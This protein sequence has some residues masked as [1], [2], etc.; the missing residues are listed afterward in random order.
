M[1]LPAAWA[2]LLWLMPFQQADALHT[3]EVAARFD[4]CAATPAPEILAWADRVLGE[5]TVASEQD[6]ASALLIR[7]GVNIAAATDP[8][9]CR[10]AFDQGD[11]AFA[12]SLEANMRNVRR[13]ATYRA[14]ADP[15]IAATQA[16]IADLWMTD[17]GGRLT[18]SQLQ[19]SDRSGAAFW[20]QRRATAHVVAADGRS[21]AAIRDLLNAYDWIDSGRFGS[22]TASQAWILVQH[23][24]DHPDFQ[25][26]ALERMEPY[27]ASGGV[28]SRDYAYLWDRVAVNTGRL[29]RYGTQPTDVCNP[30]RTLDFKPLEDPD[31]VDARRAEMGLGP[32]RA[33]LERMAAERCGVQP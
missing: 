24:D 19:T 8:T 5:E 23:A 21:T 1:A 16:L 7:A 31:T 12:R 25:Q 10:R 4:Y 6:Q 2:V 3:P 14:A 20:A 32:A 11:T 22:R 27:L 28:R 29:Q 17:Q 9:G 18:Y 13:A 15:A 26:L 33:D 30:D